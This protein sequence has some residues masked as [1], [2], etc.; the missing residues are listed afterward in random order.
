MPRKK[1]E[2]SGDVLSQPLVIRFTESEY[3]KLEKL[4]KESDCRSIGEVVRRVITGKKIICFHRDASLNDVM[5]EL[6]LIRKELKAIGV[7]INQQTHRFHTSE[8]E[9]QRAFYVRQTAQLYQ[10]VGAKVDE[11]LTIVSKLAWKWLQ[12]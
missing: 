10:H 1:M 11:L 12:G 5:E 9:A 3:K 4:H 2:N 7:N 8:T 6:A